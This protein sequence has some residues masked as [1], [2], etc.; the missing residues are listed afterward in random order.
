[1]C[2]SLEISQY[3]DTCCDRRCQEVRF[4]RV[5]TYCSAP[6]S[7]AGHRF[8]VLARCWAKRYRDCAVSTVHSDF[9]GLFD[10]AHGLLT[11]GARAA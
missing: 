6:E 1:M 7:E 5:I 9:Q 11:G 4:R 8:G 10:A 2:A 3:G